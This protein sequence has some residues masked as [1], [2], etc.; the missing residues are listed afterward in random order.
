MELSSVGVISG[1]PTAEGVFS[2]GVQVQDSVGMTATASETL[3][4]I[5]SPNVSITGVTVHSG[6]TDPQFATIT[7][8]DGS[9]ADIWGDKDSNGIATS[10]RSLKV[11]SPDGTSGAFSFDSTGHLVRFGPSTGTVFTL[12]WQSD[13]SATL[14]AYSAGGT[15]V[16]GP[17]QITIPSPAAATAV[18]KRNS[19]TLATLAAPSQND[20]QVQVTH[21]GKPAQ[22]AAVSLDVAGAITPNE[23]DIV[24]AEQT[25]PGTYDAQIPVLIPGSV[26]ASTVALCDNAANALQT[27]SNAKNVIGI[28]CMGF[29][30]AAV[31]ASDGAG[32]L[33][34]A[35][36]DTA[37]VQ[38]LGLF[39]EV[40]AVL[41]IVSPST[42]SLFRMFCDT[43]IPAVANLINDSTVIV[44]VTATIPGQPAKIG[45]FTAYGGQ[46]SFPG[47]GLA[48]LLINFDTGGACDIKG[49]WK[50]GWSRVDEQGEDHAG[51][52]EAAIADSSAT[53]GTYDVAL[54][55][56]DSHGSAGYNFSGEPTDE[57]QLG[58]FF[59]FGP[60]AI[61][62]VTGT[63]Q[64]VL[65][66]D[67]K[68]LS[69]SFSGAAPGASG[70]WSMIKQ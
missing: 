9:R 62:G 53:P 35:E 68:A 63:A 2:F 34:A 46:G 70:G 65:T 32:A 33:A 54:T 3:T 66:P 57:N 7:T 25:A 12:N 49:N 31:V 69:G 15:A 39:Y 20:F 26:I 36:I 6:S 1:T 60:A 18:I 43:G 5:G 52:L 28:V 14:V 21:C 37:C 38:S 4:V 23:L 24:L 13:T 56:T 67:G 19:H 45:S 30:A 44:S 55:V 16:V 42:T 22:N 29:T 64:G 17:T 8:S 51:G 50:G 48:P 11:T 40:N 47:S 58:T 27:V 59:G 10:L 41:S 61:D